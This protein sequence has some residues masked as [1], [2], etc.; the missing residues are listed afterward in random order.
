[1]FVLLGLVFP[2]LK[3]FLGEGVIQG[4]LNHKK[5]MAASANEAERVRIQADVNMAAFELDRRKAQRDLQLKEMEHGYLWWPKFLI[6]M[7]VA[8]YVLARFTVKTW[9]LNDYHIAVADLDTWEAGIASAVM[10]YLFLGG[11]I[12]RMIGK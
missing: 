12:K 7:S 10:A 2:F 9:G 5:D 11:E 1:M 6:M 3:S 4:Y 8:L